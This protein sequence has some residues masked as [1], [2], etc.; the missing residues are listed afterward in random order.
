MI[1][2]RISDCFKIVPVSKP[3]SD[4]SYED[5]VKSLRSVKVSQSPQASPNLPCQTFS[6][7][8]DI[9]GDIAKDIIMPVMDVDLASPE[10]P[11]LASTCLPIHPV[12]QPVTVVGIMSPSLGPAMDPAT[13]TLQSPNMS[14]SRESPGYN[15]TITVSR[16]IVTGSGSV[17]GAGPKS[18]TRPLPGN[19]VSADPALPGSIDG[20]VS[21]RPLSSTFDSVGDSLL[22]GQF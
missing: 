2:N 19:R 18:M 14:Q 11:R 7:S 15:G 8:N 22:P 16:P 20:S 4:V 6:S 12:L 3:V 1:F 5:Y 10:K 9:Q 13:S 17:L 21:G